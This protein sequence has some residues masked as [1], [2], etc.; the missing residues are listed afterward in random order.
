MNKWWILA[1]MG[2]VMG[3]ILLDETV[4]GVALPTIR[5]ELDLSVNVSH[6]LINAYLLVFTG[7]AAVGGK[8]GDIFGIRKLF[9]SSMI[10]FGTASLVCGLSSSG[11]EI[12][13]ARIVQGLGAAIIFPLSLA[14]VTLAFE[15][16]ERGLALGIYSAIGTFFLGIGPLV[17]GFVIDWFSWRWIF[18]LNIPVMFCIAL[19]VLSQWQDKPRDKHPPAFDFSG[20][21]FLVMALGLIIFALMQGP[22]WGWSSSWVMI[23][24][25]VGLVTSLLFIVVENHRAFP[26][27]ELDLF[28]QE[29]FSPCNFVLF[30]A[31]F[32]QMC[33]VIFTAL[34]LQD[35]IKLSPQMTGVILLA[36][37]GMA[38]LTGTPTG[39]MVDRFG[40][41][42]ILLASLLLS[43]LGMLWVGLIIARN[44]YIYLIPGF[45][46]WG[47]TNCAL[48]ITGRRPVLAFIA[49]EKQGQAGGILMTSQLLGG[50]VA[51]AIGSLL[52]TSS[53]SYALIFFA[54]AAVTLCGLLWSFCSVERGQ[55]YQGNT[56]Q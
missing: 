56:E 21:L 48:F 18:W 11:T 24:A 49:A 38:P 2:G 23:A 14:M 17:G 4:V 50:T 32:N 1:A 35:V 30:I 54:A 10:I 42:P 22:V 33:I 37:V 53:E 40:V 7:L 39:W 5:N 13:I 29:N 55:K 25:A 51:V 44:G 12:I 28:R 16:E 27:M 52:Y 9:I 6:W 34:Y 47:A 19:I 15:P 8:L 43:T 36:A 45:I 46:F 3:L 20:L 41:R 31:Q 26:L